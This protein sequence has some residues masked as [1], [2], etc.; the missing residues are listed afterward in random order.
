MTHICGAL[1]A[2]YS[3]VNR[4]RDYLVQIWDSDK[5]S[6]GLDFQSGPR[7]ARAT[8]KVSATYTAEFGAQHGQQYLATFLL[9]G[10]WKRNPRSFSGW[11][12]IG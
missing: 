12:C 4:L 8:V 2:A 9:S 3:R 1:L 5:S 6:G 10:R 7:T 11:Q